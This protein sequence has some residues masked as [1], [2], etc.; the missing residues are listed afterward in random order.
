M[1]FVFHEVYYFD[2]I[3]LFERYH[4]IEIA[5]LESIINFSCNVPITSNMCKIC[6]VSVFPIKNLS[7]VLSEY[8]ETP[9]CSKLRLCARLTGIFIEMRCI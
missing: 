5:A 7:R 9:Y 2:N 6:S 4:P 1:I 3:I 8:M